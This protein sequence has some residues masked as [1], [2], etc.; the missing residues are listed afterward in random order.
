M[1]CYGTTEFTEAQIVCVRSGS[2]PLLLD[3]VF[4]SQ[5]S[6]QQVVEAACH[7][8]AKFMPVVSLGGLTLVLP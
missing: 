3:V 7:G 6:K 1:N 2:G 5:V 8:G 4:C